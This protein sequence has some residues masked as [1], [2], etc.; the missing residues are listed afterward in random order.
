MAVVGEALALADKL[1][2]PDGRAALAASPLGPLVDRAFATGV[3]FSLAMA[4]K[5]LGLAEEQLDLPVLAAA[6]REL[7]AVPDQDA[8]LGAVVAHIRDAVKG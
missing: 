4:A 6:R 2:V 8:D 3:D 1:G 5:D 7:L